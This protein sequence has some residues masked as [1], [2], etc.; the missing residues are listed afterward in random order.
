MAKIDWKP[1]PFSKEW[2]ALR[3][4]QETQEVANTTEEIVV[5]STE[6]KKAEKSDSNL[7]AILERLEALEQENKELKSNTATKLK[8]AKKVNNDP[9]KFSY[10]LRGWVPVISYVSKRQD[11]T[12]DLV[13]KNQF[14]QYD[15]NHILVLSLADWTTAEVDVIEF[16]KNYEI[17]EKVEAYDHHN[18][19][20]NNQSLPLVKAYTFK[21]KEHWTFTVLPNS[22][23][24]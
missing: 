14:W 21:T 11:P 3:A 1:H 23:N 5:K 15:S 8:D 7:Q 17:S 2:R 24:G 13:Y 20:I 6:P 22:I 4:Q 16:W 18:E 19:L 9:K 12:K 10:K